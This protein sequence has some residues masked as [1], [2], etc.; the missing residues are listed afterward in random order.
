MDRLGVDQDSNL[1]STLASPSFP[2][3]VINDSC[4][5]DRSAVSHELVMSLDEQIRYKGVNSN[6]LRSGF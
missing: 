6:K 2:Q 5:V 1:V 4:T 3:L